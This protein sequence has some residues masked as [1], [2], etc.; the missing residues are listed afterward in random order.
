[1]KY[2]SYPILLV[3]FTVCYH[4][5]CSPD[6]GELQPGSEGERDAGGTGS[7][8]RSGGDSGNGR[9]EDAEVDAS[10]TDAAADE[11]GMGKPGDSCDIEGARACS[12]HASTL[13][14]VCLNGEWQPE[15]PCEDDERCDTATG[16]T[17]GRCLPILPECAGH[18]AGERFCA[19]NAIRVC[20]DLVSFEDTACPVNATCQM[21][22]DGG[23]CICNTGFKSDDA[24]GCADIDECATANGGCDVLTTCVN[25]DGSRTCGA[26]PDGYAGDGETGCRPVLTGLEVAD[27][28]L[29]PDFDPEVFAYQVFVPLSTQRVT[30]T[31]SAN[32]EFT[33]DINGDAVES[34]GS[35][36]SPLLNLGSN[37]LE[38]NVSQT[39]RPSSIY[40]I[41]VIRVD[42]NVYLKALNPEEGDRFGHSV[43]ISGD[44]IVVGAYAEDSATIG[45]QHPGPGIDEDNDNA[46]GSGATY[47]FVRNGNI[48]EQQAYLKALNAEADDHFGT[49]VAISGDTIVV[50]ASSEDGATVGPQ[51]P[52]PSIDE[53]NDNAS[54]SGATYVF[55][56]NGTIWTQQAYLKALNAETGDHFGS[57]VSIS[58]DTIVVGAQDE[59]SAIA[60]VQHPGPDPVSDDDTAD[61]GGAVYVFVRNGTTWT[62]QAYLKALN[63]GG[64]EGFAGNVA[65]SGDTI[66]VSAVSE[67][68]ATAGVQHP[69]PTIEESNN[70]ARWA[71]AAY[72]FVRNGTTWYQQAYLKA[73]NAEADDYFGTSVAISGDTIV[74]GA[75]T[76]DGDADGMQHPGPEPGNDSD[77]VS[78]SGAAYVF[79]R[80]GTIWTQQAYLKALNAEADDYFGSG[81][82]I[83]GDNIVIGATGEQG[84]TAG[85]EYPGPGAGGD[86]DAAFQSGAAYLFVRSDNTW[87]QQAYIKASNAEQS[88]FFGSSVTIS[89]NTILIGAY[90][91]DSAAA[92]ASVHQPGAVTDDNSAENSGAAYVY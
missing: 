22:I 76:E 83:S 9:P 85:V 61:Q 81:V 13:P 77:S 17:Q 43:A 20:P 35:W 3:T 27:N 57:S 23:E 48:W 16:T 7:S 47:V 92:G 6:A 90:G 56:R 46:S 63:V 11:P 59:L 18:Q 31:V 33:V 60:G 40:T 14:L 12:G 39:G 89:G 44:T 70:D 15:E 8:A 29:S 50:G 1:M 51:H 74:V 19:V 41:E 68:S 32:A 52:G 69:G 79:V 4:F 45:V 34:S 55:V 88:D 49:S 25:V 5:A 2:S 21:G 71:G 80:N 36:Q 62:Q 75:S 42:V 64:Q 38:I 65:I 72:V 26:C 58:G 73:S 67:N 24:N 86:S 66:V 54:G 53:D 91:E 10:S 28:S 84:A 82:A 87:T 37:S 30:V 78:E